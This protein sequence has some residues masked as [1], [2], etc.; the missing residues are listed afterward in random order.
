MKISDLLVTFYQ[1]RI[2]EIKSKAEIDIKT[3]NACHSILNAVFFDLE[4]GISKGKEI[5]GNWIKYNEEFFKSIGLE[6]PDFSS[7]LYQCVETLKGFGIESRQNNYLENK[8]G[9]VYSLEVKNISK[10]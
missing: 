7:T 4:N 3:T 6:G 10:D 2:L 1:N 5:S 8:K 9:Y